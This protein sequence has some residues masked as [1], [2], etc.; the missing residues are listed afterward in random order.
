[1]NELALAMRLPPTQVDAVIHGKLDITADAA[2][3]LGSFFGSTAKY[4]IARVHDLRLAA[5]LYVD[6][7][8]PAP[9]RERTELHALRDRVAIGRGLG[10]QRQMI[11]LAENSQ[12]ERAGVDQDAA[13]TLAR[14]GA[15]ATNRYGG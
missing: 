4:R 1:M 7:R 13:D 15:V 10:R 3:G 11:G 8:N 12:P 14:G 9:G 2:F 5:Q 6:I